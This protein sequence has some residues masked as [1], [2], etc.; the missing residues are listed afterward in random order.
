MGVGDMGNVPRG[1]QAAVNDLKISWVPKGCKWE[2]VMA[3]KIFVYE[4]DSRSSAVDKG[5]GGNS[6]VAEGDI[7]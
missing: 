3:C 2:L 4:S 5:M 7:A 1:Y 6:P